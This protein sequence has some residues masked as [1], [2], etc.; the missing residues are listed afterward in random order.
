MDELEKF[1]KRI[2]KTIIKAII[3][4]TLPFLLI[5]AMIAGAAYVIIEWVAETVNSSA[6]EY[7]TH[8][9]INVDGTVTT[10]MTAQDL[11]DKMMKD[12]YDEL[13]TYLKGPAELKKLL[14]AE[15]V[16][17]LPDTRSDVTKEIDWE[18]IKNDNEIQGII[19]FKRH[20]ADGNEYYLT[21]S[22]PDEFNEY[23]DAI[24]AS[25]G[26]P[27]SDALDFVLKHFTLKK[28]SSG[29]ISTSTT[30]NSTN[31]ST[32]NSITSNSTNNSTTN[33]ITNNTPSNTTNNTTSTN[34]SKTD[35]QTTS[36][37]FTGQLDT[38]QGNYDW[39]GTYTSHSGITYKDYK[40]GSPAS[41]SGNK[42]SYGNGYY[43]GQ[44]SIGECGCAATSLAIILSGTV[45][46]SITPDQ[47][48][49]ELGNAGYTW[50]D[51]GSAVIHG[52]ESRGIHAER[53]ENPSAQQIVDYLVQGKVMVAGLGPSIFC[54]VN[55]AVA[56]V[57][58]NPLT[59]E[60]YV[61]DPAGMGHSRWI[62]ADYISDCD[63]YV[64]PVDAGK[65][66]IKGGGG[67]G[68]TTSNNTRPGYQAIIATVTKIDKRTK[69]EGETAED[70]AQDFGV[71]IEQGVEYQVSTKPINYEDLVQ[72]Y[73]L[74]FDLLWSLLVIGQS[75][76]FIMDL[77]DLAYESEIE[78]S[79]Y[80]NLKITSDMD[81]YSYEEQTNAEVTGSIGYTDG[82]VIVPYHRIE[83]HKH[84]PYNNEKKTGSIFKEVIT[85][86]NTA[87]IALTKAHTWIADF[88]LGY[89]TKDSTNN[90]MK[91]NELP[92][93][94]KLYGST[95]QVATEGRDDDCE[96]IQVI[97]NQIMD[98]ANE[99]YKK[100]AKEEAKER[101]ESAK[102]SISTGTLDARWAPSKSRIY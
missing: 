55:H 95:K 76:G 100:K 73:T 85:Q 83:A 86:D 78:V 24:N 90:S 87:V 39:E 99:L 1:A 69:L 48:Y 101:T 19:K 12:G 9:N 36:A 7:N 94:K 60:V 58:V 53:I 25:S 28:G 88:D 38:S 98:E 79:I 68:I 23:V 21:Y 63:R 40:Q 17:Q 59:N 32:N 89:T 16:T 84:E 43:G 30:S 29:S 67:S 3:R 8:V 18:A 50:L 15:L 42:G 52:F 35:S 51:A 71:E 72:P 26:N 64:V 102:S 20:D 57:D 41:W 6:V 61:M 74:P 62:S 97:V 93:Q 81:G 37:N 75:K 92:D 45:D 5:I 91:V 96:K 47:T 33:N 49:D 27:R 22:P 54:T 10:E 34:S 4:V 56:I 46:D 80:D 44:G 31:N 2:G 14:N 82:N 13:D 77:A 66:G 65:G 11:W 70:A